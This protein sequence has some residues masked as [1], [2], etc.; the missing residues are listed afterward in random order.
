MYSGIHRR[1][2]VSIALLAFLCAAALLGGCA[3][4]ARTPN[5]TAPESVRLQLSWL[6][7]IEW[8]GIYV[9]EEKGY[10]AD[11]GLQVTILPGGEDA[12]GNY[13]N[14]IDVVREGRAD[15]GVITGGNLLQARAGGAPIVAIAAIYQRHPL[16]FTSLAEKGITKPADLIG[17]TIQIS[18]DSRLLLDAMLTIQGIDPSAITVEE[19][20]D[21]TIGP[22]T[23]GEADVIDAFITNELVALKQEHY[24]VNNLL[25][26]DYGIEEYPNVIFTTEK[27]IT[28]HPERV[29]RFLRATVK[30][31]QGAVAEPQIVAPLAVA[32][33]SSLRLEKEREAMLL[34]VPLLNPPGSKPGMM[35]AETWEVTER[36]LQEQGLLDESLDLD[37]AYTLTFLQKIY[38][39]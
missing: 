18:P 25:P 23:R 10:Y 2:R 34:S 15:F 21:F 37:A 8:A 33:D 12:E 24:A 19:R 17:R 11:Q 7:T 9:A 4:P 1:R 14:S 16:G 26:V 38:G 36:I 22:L 39:T 5:T 27:M 20:T 30:G 6:H 28:E 35:T 13:I 32:H 31:L 3:T 29:E